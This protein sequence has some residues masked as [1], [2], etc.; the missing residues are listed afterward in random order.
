MFSC[1]MDVV[2]V[3]SGNVVVDRDRSVDIRSAVRFREVQA[4]EES[5]RVSQIFLTVSF[6]NDDDL[7]CQVDSQ[8][9]S[10]GLL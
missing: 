9:L 7:V 10:R 1:V 8:S 3:R 4:R 2:S 5:R 6:V